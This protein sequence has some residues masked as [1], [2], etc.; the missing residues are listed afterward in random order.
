MN[1]QANKIKLGLD[2]FLVAQGAAH[3]SDAFKALPRYRLHDIEMLEEMVQNY[4][5]IR[6]PTGYLDTRTLQFCGVHEFLEHTSN[7]I[8]MVEGVTAKGTPSRK[9]TPLSQ[10]FRESRLRDE[11]TYEGMTF[12]PN[13]PPVTANAQYN[14]FREFRITP[15]RGDLS[16]YHALMDHLFGGQHK[17]RRYVEWW[18]AMRLR[19]PEVKPM[20]FIILYGAIQ[21]EGKTRL[22]QIFQR[23]FGA[24]GKE[25]PGSSFLERFNSEWIARRLF[26]MV[27]ELMLTDKKE[28][29]DLIKDMISRSEIPVERKYVPTYYLP[30]CLGYFVTTNYH[31]PLYLE[32]TDRR[33]FMVEVCQGLSA[34]EAR[35]SPELATA[36]ATFCDSPEGQAALS[37]YLDRLDLEKFSPHA[38][39]PMTEA[40]LT[41][42]D[43]SFTELERFARDVIDDPDQ[44]W[45]LFKEKH[46]CDLIEATEI[47]SLGDAP[48]RLQ[49]TS[50]TAVGNALSKLGCKQVNHGKPVRTKQG[51]KRLWA[52]RN[53]E[54]WLGATHEKLAQHYNQTRKPAAAKQTPKPAAEQTAAPVEAARTPQRPAPPRVDRS[55]VKQTYHDGKG[56]VMRDRDEKPRRKRKPATSSKCHRCHHRNYDPE[57]IHCK[58]CGRKL[59]K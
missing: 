9:R 22:G 29:A 24:Y 7:R 54:K 11:V 42:I 23:Q 14:T 17:A 21:G 57:R 46:P 5:F 8:A 39:P 52:L 41:A 56:I 19:H 6:S 51:L 2:D 49:R 53:P 55:R 20:N 47:L 45:R 43:S 58:N 50:T 18:I 44:Y 59:A 12:I 27:S 25:I 1:S 32:P 48:N 4:T 35:L 10:V 34:Q 40:K 30:D 33:A 26:V 37:Y 3:A 13:G 38:P 15:K 36:A 16:A 28:A 31:N